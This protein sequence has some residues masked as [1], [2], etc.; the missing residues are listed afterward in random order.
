MVVYFWFFLFAIV[1]CYFGYP[2]ILALVSRWRGCAVAVSP[3]EAAR[4][5][6]IIAVCNEEDVLERKLNNI[7]SLEFPSQFE[8]LIGSD[9]STDQ[10]ER[11]LKDYKDERLRPYVYS[12]RRGKIAVIA[13]LVTQA[14]GDIVVFTDARQ[15]FAKNAI[16]EL[17]KNFGDPKVGCVSGELVFHSSQGTT[18]K[19]IQLY[20]DYEKWLR[21]MESQIHSMLGATGAIYAIRKELFVKPPPDVVLDD[22]YIPLKIVAG[23]YRAIFEENARA[24]DHV[25]E[26]GGEEYS[27]KTRTL[28][29]NFQIFTLFSELFDLRKS[30]VALQLLFHKFLRVVVPFLMIA[31]FATNIFLIPHGWFFFSVMLG[32]ILFYGLALLGWWSRKNS[33]FL[34]KYINKLS[35]I[36]YVFC[37]LN[38]SA[39]IGFVRFVKRDQ[40]V[41]WQKARSAREAANC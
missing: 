14:K 32:Q 11:I 23:G 41:A 29:G 4:V 19:G 10:T 28:Y 18:G 25:A 1:F 36:P 31:F 9:G 40:A 33:S 8:I 3:S 2:S 5:S 30:P 16:V 21:R 38:Y 6:V 12:E 35:A 39:F 27:R 37:L 26:D 15:Q 20:W 34:D 22:M 24:Y 17:V 7:F 13:D